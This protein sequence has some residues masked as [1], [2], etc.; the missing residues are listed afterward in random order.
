[1][2]VLG[3]TLLPVW[4]IVEVDLHENG[5]LVATINALDEDFVCRHKLFSITATIKFKTD[6]AINARSVEAEVSRYPCLHH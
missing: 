2:K 6:D 5:M 1:M 3:K 4:T